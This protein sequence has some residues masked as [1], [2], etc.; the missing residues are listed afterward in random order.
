MG[1]LER[2]AMDPIRLAKPEQA[3]C[4]DCGARVKG[5]VAGCRALFGELQIRNQQLGDLNVLRMCVDA[6]CLQHPEPYMHSTKSQTGH[7]V[8]MCW[9]L[10][11]GASPAVWKSAHSRLRVS[12]SQPKLSAPARR[13]TV[14]LL[15]VF[16]V[17]EVFVGRGYLIFQGVKD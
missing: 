9:L 5:G 11:Y 1:K 12:N 3:V 6:Y 13:G 4:P 14:T 17:A 8:S 2:E 16:V 10:E 7:L 15:D